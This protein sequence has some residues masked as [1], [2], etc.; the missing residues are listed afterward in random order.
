MLKL[1]DFGNLK[2]LVVYDP[3]DEKTRSELA[4]KNLEVIYFEELMNKG[5]SITKISNYDYKWQPNDCYTFSYTSGTTGPPKGAM[6]SH[7]NV[8]AFARSLQKHPDLKVLETD[9]YA[10]YL[11]LPHSMERCISIG[12]F[13]FGAHMM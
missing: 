10:S 11:P 3:L 4:S 13:A 8:L 5:A 9:V 12:L 2:N 6:L 7:K 1:E